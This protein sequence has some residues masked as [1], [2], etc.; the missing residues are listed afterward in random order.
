MRAL[1]GFVAGVLGTLVFHQIAL[2]IL[3][4][5]GLAPF[6][7]YPMAPTAPLGVPAVLSLAFWGGVWGILY[8]FVHHR[9]P[10]GAGYWVAAFLFGAIATSFVGLFILPF[11]KGGPFAAGGNVPVLIVVFLINGAWGVGTGVVLRW[12]EGRFG[13]TAPVAA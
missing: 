2:A 1:Y 9:F 3:H 13:R 8:A 11:V 5:V 10:G 12:L 7:A 4:A 6:G